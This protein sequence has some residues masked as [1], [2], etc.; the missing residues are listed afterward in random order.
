MGF[1][2]NMSILGA[3]IGLSFVIGVAGISMLVSAIKERNKAVSKKFFI[4]AISILIVCVVGFYFTIPL[5]MIVKKVEDAN[6]NY[7][8]THIDTR[9]GECA[10][11]PK[12]PTTRADK[13]GKIISPEK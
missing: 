11:R 3:L 1:E 9:T 13:E 10:L 6:T 2:M 5:F 8:V 4:W 7:T 12:N